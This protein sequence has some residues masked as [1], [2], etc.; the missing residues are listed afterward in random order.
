MRHACMSGGVSGILSEASNVPALCA[1]AGVPE[2][3]DRASKMIA[4]KTRIRR[5]Y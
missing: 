2:S 3:A 4:L 5:T 1:A